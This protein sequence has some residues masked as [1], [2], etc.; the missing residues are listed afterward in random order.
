MNKGLIK[1]YLLILVCL[2]SVN[3]LFSQDSIV[4]R[5]K[6]VANKS[7]A[8]KDVS[9]SAAGIEVAPVRTNS[10]GKFTIKVLTG[11]E[12][13]LI[14]PI[15]N[16]KSKQVFL[17][18]RKELV[19]S[20]AEKSMKSAYDD[21]LFINQR[22]KKRRDIVASFKDLNIDKVKYRNVVSIDQAFQGE[23]SGMLTISHS[24]MPGQGTVNFLRGISSPFTSNNPLYIVDG[25]P[26]ENPGLFES[27]IDGNVYNPLSTIAPSDISE[28]TI[29]KDPAVLSLYGTKAS[30]GVI[31]INTLDPKATETTINFSMKLGANLAPDNLIPQLNDIQYKALANEILVSSPKKEENFPDDYPGLYVNIG[32]QD[33]Y[34]YSHNTN[35]QN[36]IFSNS[37]LSDVY[38]SIK[39]GSD[40]AKYGLSIGHHN[41]E[42]IIKNNRYN[43]LNVRLISDLNIFPRFQMKINANLTNSNSFL[44]ESGVAFQ[45][46]PIQTSLSKPPILG[47][48][49]YDED[50]VQLPIIDEVDEL[51]TSNPLAVI[52]NFKGENKNYRF[53]SSVLG[54][55]DISQALKFNTLFGLNF[56]TMKES[57]FMPNIGMGKHFYGEAINVSQGLNN[58]LISFYSD[59]YFNYKKL[60][61]SNHSFNTSLGLRIH[62]N[63][64]ETDFGEAMNMPEN[65][66]YSSLQ[67]GQN[68]LRRISGSNAVWNWLSVYNQ[69]SYKYKD[70]YLINTGTSADFSSLTGAEANTAFH[71][72]DVPFNMFYSIG[73]GWRISNEAFLKNV[74]GLENAMLRIS[75]GT[76]GN[77]DIGF[78]IALDYYQLSRYREAS[79]LVPGTIANKSLK[80]EKIDQFDVGLNFALWG[81][82][83]RFRTNYYAKTTHDMLIYEP[84]KSYIGFEYRAVNAGVVENNGWEFSFFQRIID[85]QKF[86]WDIS[87]NI[88]T[89][90]NKVVDIYGERLLVPFEGGEFIIQEGEPLN[91]FYGYQFKGVFSTYDEAEKAALLSA[92][93]IP[94]GAGDAIFEDLSG[95]EN[96]P[97]GIINNYDKVNLGSP[98]PELFGSF[99]NTFQYK[100][101]SFNMMI[102]FVYGNEVFN[103]TRYLNERMVDLSNQSSNV[104]KRWQFEG[105]ITDVPRAL[106]NDPVGNSDFSSRWIEDGSFIR[107]KYLTLSYSIPGKFLVFKNADFYITAT[108][109]ITFDKYLGYDPEFSYSYNAMQQGVDYGLIPQTRQIIFG[110]TVGL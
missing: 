67:Y 9:V 57:I 108:N 84:Q 48:Y 10:D 64:L 2:T 59:S 13:L 51:G 55:V 99:S 32:E 33:Y 85:N 81:D 63:S 46:S 60:F 74:K 26:L 103:Y 43:R 7:L 41:Q 95:P 29:Y 62:T 65:D 27:H 70:K 12:L 19:I 77:G 37:L 14:N 75:Y 3:L 42:G 25:I 54:K 36:L 100:R 109:L 93:G 78:Y 5:G 83:T 88:T 47:P 87:S 35:W 28:V 31:L 71:I 79:G 82:R 105:D 94:F 20:L 50:G 76:T 11:N 38:L 72:S 8:L 34:R 102:Q 73:V 45:T 107:L 80:N 44:Q 101:W 58:Q 53:I 39:G 91:C 56:N 98:I 110:A 69:I 1:Y 106:W 17:N 89:L 22:V 21:L 18:N 24:G 40:I 15:G 66:Q 97:D 68:D 96:K 30:N 104:L 49:Q 86:V 4:V 16:Y 90:N 61:N 6:V 92:K 52:E 23:V